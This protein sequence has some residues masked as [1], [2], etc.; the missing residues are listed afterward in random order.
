MPLAGPFYVERVNTHT[1]FFLKL[2]SYLVQL[3]IRLGVHNK[4]I[5][6][7]CVLPDASSISLLS[8]LYSS[9]VYFGKQASTLRPR[10][11]VTTVAGPRRSADRLDLSD[12]SSMMCPPG[13]TG[14][15]KITSVF[16]RTA[17][18]VELAAE[19]SF[20]ALNTKNK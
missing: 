6:S 17:P 8:K 10:A 12:A 1:H 18:G 7:C 19:V 11:S 16:F 3:C 15:K 4:S 13:V 14:G 2:G 9:V 20:A 5:A